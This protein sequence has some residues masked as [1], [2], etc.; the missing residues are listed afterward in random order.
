M[1][2]MFAFLRA[3]DHLRCGKL[4]N[5]TYHASYD[6]GCARIKAVFQ[7]LF[8]GRRGTLD[9]FAGCDLID[10]QVGQYTNGT[11]FKHDAL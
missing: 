1:T 7:Q 3:G 11:D 2:S 9:D 10:Q 8:E 5:V 4:N 6:V